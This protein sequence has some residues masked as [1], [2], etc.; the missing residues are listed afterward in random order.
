VPSQ[1]WAIYT[2]KDY[3]QQK[4]YTPEHKPDIQV[5][6]NNHQLKINILLPTSILPTSLLN[7]V[8]P[9][10]NPLLWNIAVRYACRN[11]FTTCIITA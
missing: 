8:F 10:Y 3:R 4:Q 2:L 5:A 1:H 11:Y 7:N 6:Q 9:N